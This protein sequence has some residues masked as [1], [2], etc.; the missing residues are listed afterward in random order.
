M[1]KVAI[2]LMQQ[3]Y[4]AEKIIRLVQP[5]NSLSEIAVNKK[6]YDDIYE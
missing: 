3:L 2:P 6:L 4:Q 5:N 1:A